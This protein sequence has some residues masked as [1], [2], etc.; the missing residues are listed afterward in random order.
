[1]QEIGERKMSFRGVIMASQ[2]NAPTFD[3]DETE[4]PVLVKAQKYLKQRQSG[5]LDRP[6]DSGS[7]EDWDR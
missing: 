1:M 5:Q 6:S 4:A 3:P 2:I 7:Q